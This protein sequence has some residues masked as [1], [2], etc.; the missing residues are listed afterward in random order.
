MNR[1]ILTST[2]ALC[3]A[4]LALIGCGSGANPDNQAPTI[5]STAPSDAFVDVPFEYTVTADG[6]APIVFSLAS[7]PDGMSIDGETGAVTWTPEEEGSVSV[8]ITAMNLAGSDS[9]SFE[10]E[11]TTPGGPMFTTTPPTEGA[12]GV[13]YAYDPEVVANGS[14]TWTA[15]TALA[16]VTIDEATG[17]VRWT[18]SGSQV[19][20]QEVTIRATE[21]EGGAFAEQSF[22]VDVDQGAGPAVITSVAPGQVFEGETWTY[23]AAASGAPVI[24][25][26]LVTPSGGTPAVGVSIDTMPPEGSAVTLSWETVGITPGDYTVAIQVDNGFGDPDVQE[27]TVTVDARPPAPVIDL[28][29]VPPPAT[30]FVGATYMYDVNLTPESDS[31]G[32]IWS[33]VEGSTVPSDLPITINRDTGEVTFTAS[34]ANG[35]IEYSYEVR[36]TNVIG[37]SDT[38]TISVDAVFP[39]AT[40]VLTV[41]PATAFTLE[42]GE[43]FPGASA[44]ATG[45]PAPTL[46][47]SGSL[48]DFLE[49][50]ELTGLLSAS[51][52]KPAP[53]E[54]DIGS[55]SFD[56]VA[57][58]TEGM[59]SATI[60]IEV[61]AAPPSVESITPAAGRRQSDVDVVVRGSGF[62]AGAAPTL[63]LERD[64]FS[65]AVPTIFVDDTTLTATVPT[66]VTRPS[67]VYDVVVDQG[68]RTTL[69]KR[70]TVTEGDG[71]TLSGTIAMDLTLTAIDSPYHVTADVRVESGV[72]VTVEPGAVLMFDG[73]TNRRIDVGVNSAGAIVADGGVPGAGDQIV[74]TRFQAVGGPTPS[75]HYR[76]LRFGSNVIGAS[77]LLR[78]VVVEFGGRRN[79]AADQGALE[80]LS[81]SAPAVRESIIRESL[82]YGLYAASGAGSDAIDWFADNTVTANARSPISMG[83]DDVS[84]LGANLGLTGNGEDRVFVRTST[85]TRADA[86]WRN[87]G[88]PFFLNQGLVIRNASVMTLEPGTELRFGGGRRVQV[89]TGSEQGTLIA[90]GTPESPI[91]MVPDSG[92]AGDWDGIQLDDNV[93]TG[94]VLRNVRIEGFRGGVSGGVRVDN[95]DVPGSQP[96]IIENC[97]IQ[98]G[99]PGAVGVYLAGSAGVSSF[100]NNVV[101]VDS[102]AVDAAL[103]GF[104]GLIRST[105]VYE[106]PLQVRSS[107]AT[108]AALVWVEPMASDTSTQPIRPTG[109]LTVTNGSLTIA[110]GTQVQMPLNGQLQMN[111]SQLVVT[112]NTDDPVVFSPAPGVAYWNRIRLRG[113]GASGVSR[114]D[115]AVLDG[116]GAD[117]ALSVSESRAALVVEANGGVPATPAVSNTVVTGSNGYGMV[118]FDTTHC[119]GDCNDNNVSGSRFSALRMHAN[120]VGRF[121]NGNVLAG[122]NTSGT[123]GHEGVWVVG[124]RVDLEATWPANDVAYVVQGN[125]DLRQTSPLDPVPT[126][127]LS[128]G[129]EL[130][131]A[132]DRRLRVGEGGDAILDAQGTADDPITFTTLD[133]ATPLYWRGIEFSQGSDG[134][135]LDH[136]V[137]SYGG[138]NNN[139]GS[140]NF[141]AG[142]IVSVGVASFT[143]ANNFAGVIS[144]GSA[145]M[146]LGPTTDRVYTGNGFDCIR[147]VASD[148]CEQL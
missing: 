25:W 19:G 147:D 74:F 89:S 96:T 143:D 39:P 113:P 9:Q 83:A 97:L 119:A 146:F 62:V 42:V 20:S 144:V 112:G 87:Y 130:R 35:E 2:A 128:P 60:D 121:G 86:S 103:L 81:G 85:V 27:S 131:F 99:D 95:P 29:T 4:A 54:V 80:A 93:G 138:R 114:I 100:E 70:F 135:I 133:S 18:P 136:V 91:R 57:T 37:E 13:E 3:A 76:G 55:Y 120:F 40:P 98:S 129:S 15:P 36:V 26:S 106:S 68:S 82:N 22:S 117:P 59:D 94:T 45:N 67:G 65:E 116:A 139:T 5:T 50:D 1:T 34:E 49:F 88:V 107:T 127:T 10:L 137:V 16:G 105:N 41:T 8:T 108:D 31:P 126:L 142:S 72:T 101:D 77:N 115:H 44:T 33:I 84:T 125:V 7:G 111:E 12:V 102:F 104:N 145:P 124:D 66:D 30:V 73:N 43:S 64:G 58:N 61:I 48:P 63:V 71:Q 140:V 47:L 32:V 52:V 134:S 148:T 69:A 11:V 123:P 109:N 28:V 92:A 38:A 17:A 53:E 24:A 132:E 23:D 6:L 141:F 75:G 90:T 122:N 46:S 110:S 51:S 21:D 14:V 79:S 56:V 118:F 78:N